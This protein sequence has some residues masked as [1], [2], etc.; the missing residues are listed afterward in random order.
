MKH[1]KLLIGLSVL[2][3]LGGGAACYFYGRP[4]EKVPAK[5]QVISRMPFETRK[6]L[7][8]ALKEVRIA[9]R[10]MTNLIK[11]LPKFKDLQGKNL[12]CF[13]TVIAEGTEDELLKFSLI[14]HPSFAKT[15]KAWPFQLTTP[16][17]YQLP[18]ITKSVTLRKDG[19]CE[20]WLKDKVLIGANL[21][22]MSAFDISVQ[23]K[24]GSYQFVNKISPNDRRGQIHVYHNGQ[25]N[26][27]ENELSI[28][29]NSPRMLQ[30]IEAINRSL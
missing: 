25:E 18:E 16:L 6:I 9:Q 13:G 4:D 29:A 20:I 28:S 3:T 5:T 14:P 21:L 15:E 2:A 1:K 26:V 23:T 24:Q 19:P 8:N 12:D 30:E 27:Y 7:E 11:E 22:H 10:D 17:A